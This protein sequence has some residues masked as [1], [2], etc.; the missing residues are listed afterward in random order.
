MRK[1]VTETGILLSQ[2]TEE[3]AYRLQVR[4][5][6]WTKVRY[7]GAAVIFTVIF[8]ALL[9]ALNVF[10]GLASERF[11]LSADMTDKSLF[12]ISDKTLE[13]LAKL[14]YDAELIVLGDEAT[15]REYASSATNSSGTPAGLGV[16]AHKYIVET[17]DRY[18]EASEHITVHYVD[19]YY[20]PGFFTDR[21]HLPVTDNLD[22]DPVIIVYSPDTY[23]YRYIRASL[24]TGDNLGKIPL[25]NRLNTAIRYT[26]KPDMKKIAVVSGHGEKALVYFSAVMED[27]GYMVET[28]DLPNVEAI[29][30]DVHLLVIGDPTRQYSENDV[31]KIDDFLLNGGELG[32][33]MLVLADLD[34]CNTDTQLRA[35]L[36][37]W[38]IALQDECVFDP[39]H[40]LVLRVPTFT[41]E[42]SDVASP[43][44]GTL[45][46]GEYKLRFQLGK[47]RALKQLYES[48]NGV[49][50]YP[51]LTTADSAFSRFQASSSLSAAKLAAVKREESD[52]AGPFPMGLLAL[53]TRTQGLD[54]YNTSV[55]VFGSASLLDDYFISNV[56]SSNQA[57]QEYV[58]QLVNFMAAQSEDKFE[59]I[60]TVSLLTDTLKWDNHGQVVFVFICTVAVIPLLL[61]LVGFIVWRKRKFL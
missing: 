19:P 12:S 25:E 1:K 49:S 40:S 22:D 8:L 61:A 51:L 56:D 35:Y 27:D 46:S 57:T 5:S 2:D 28:L 4:K 26:T 33:S 20:N 24:F 13:S 21:N 42:Y 48:Q 50:V 43:M 7:G 31:K 10:V 15:W 55:A 17:L 16:S 18:A 11:N 52:T 34:Y 53:R 14:E 59:H 58:A 47:A 6:F 39:D 36:E 45:S 23:R 44:T 41:V 38:G 37:E 60:Q 9:I 29:P 54:T 3:K 30:D 32:K